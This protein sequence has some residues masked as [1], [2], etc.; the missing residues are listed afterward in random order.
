MKNCGKKVARHRGIG[1]N[2]EGND[3]RE[4]INVSDKL[5]SEF[6]MTCPED[7]A[8]PSPGDE[9][10]RVANR[11]APDPL[12]RWMCRGCRVGHP[13][14]TTHCSGCGR[15]LPAAIKAGLVDRLGPSAN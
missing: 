13:Q 2:R 5:E 4:V 12:V 9:G 3:S 14:G 15:A 10:G 6:A 8:P 11:G 1:S 7:H